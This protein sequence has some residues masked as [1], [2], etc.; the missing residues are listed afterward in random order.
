[1]TSRR[2]SAAKQARPRSALPSTCPRHSRPSTTSHPVATFQPYV[3]VGLN[4]TTFFDTK[5]VPEL[6]ADG[7]VDLD[8]D[9]SFGLATVIAG[10]WML[11][12]KMLLSIE[13]RW[14]N[15]ETDADLVVT[16]EGSAPIGT[17]KIDPWVYAIYLGYRF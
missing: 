7:L 11:S 14:I 8:L 3:G 12:D 9:D 5:L 16:G 15:I 10:D 4:W 17:V 1:M 2:R 13:A 6:A